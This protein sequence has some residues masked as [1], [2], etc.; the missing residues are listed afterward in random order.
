MNKQNNIELLQFALKERYESQHKI[1]E[2]VQSIGFWSLGLLLSAGVW[3]L[4]SEVVFT[5]LQKFISIAGISTGFIILRFVYLSDLLKGFRSQQRIAADIEAALGYY[6]SIR[7]PHSKQ[8][9]Y[10]KSWR[11]AGKKN[12]DGNFFKSTFY[13]LYVGF[14]FLIISIIFNGLFC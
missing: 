7:K 1:R 6:S 2:R 11:E 4:K 13:L 3:F 5:N 14:A 8:S 12:C 10:P 9:I